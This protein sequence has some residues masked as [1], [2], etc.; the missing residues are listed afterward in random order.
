MSIG[1]DIGKD[2][3][4]IIGF[5]HNGKVV[6]RR[7]F[8]RLALDA[9]FE[10]LPRCVVGMEACLSAHFVSRRLRA[11]GFEPRIIPAI[12]VKPFL[13]GRKNDFNDAEAIAE[14][15]LRPNFKLVKEKTLEQLDLQVCHRVRSRLV[16][17]RT[18]I[19]NQIHAF[20]IEHGIAIRTGAN[21]LRRSLPEILLQRGEELLTSVNSAGC[22]QCSFSSVGRC[23]GVHRGFAWNDVWPRRA[24]VP[25]NLRHDVVH[26][27]HRH[28]ETDRRRT[29]RLEDD[30][31]THPDQPAGGID[32]RPAGITGIYRCIGLDHTADLTA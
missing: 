22:A 14:A 7:K 26:R 3:F 2:V 19:I 30:G 6:L 8:R 20:L 29:S 27:V 32:Q 31:R 9:V 28:R 11:L 15:A 16:S 4:H 10:K 21:S 23:G 1:I 25:D 24:S 12:Y 5:D 17:R 18:A 13:K